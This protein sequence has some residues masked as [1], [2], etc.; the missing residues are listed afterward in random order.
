MPTRDYVRELKL[1]ATV[2]LVLGCAAVFYSPK[3]Q[4]MVTRRC[5]RDFRRSNAENPVPIA[6]LASV[7]AQHD[8]DCVPSRSAR[9][10]LLESSRRLRER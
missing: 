1:N 7:Y 8:A 3:P 10:K 6:D 2:Y 4:R 9:T 5:H